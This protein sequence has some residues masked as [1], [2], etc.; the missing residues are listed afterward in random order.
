M[1]TSLPFSKKP[2]TLELKSLP[3][4]VELANR[5]SDYVVYGI[6]VTVLLIPGILIGYFLYTTSLVLMIAGLVAIVL[7]GFIIVR[8]QQLEVLTNS[9]RLQNASYEKLGEDIAMLSA[10]VGVP[11]VDVVSTQHPVINAY[12][13]GFARPYTIVLH[14]AT[15]EQLEYDEL[16]TVLLHEMG[17]VK[18]RHTFLM[19]FL[20]PLS[21]LPVVGPI[22]SWVTGFWSRRAEYTSDR[23]AVA[24]T[25]DPDLV[26]RALI[27][28][29]VGAFIGDYF[30]KEQVMYQ[31]WITRGGMRRFIQTFSTHPYLVNRIKAIIR[32][33][34]QQGYA[35]ADDLRQFIRTAPK[36]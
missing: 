7:V 34:D 26:I 14:S 15:I 21:V 24:M 6:A 18:Y 8:F 1:S 19:Q 13:F 17:H 22:T 16:Q 5:T 2:K 30:T 25:G 33:A 4:A 28:V 20:M 11:P 31:E 23:L 29:H 9:M 27:K 12:A 10:A 36:S 3:R 32:F 35:M